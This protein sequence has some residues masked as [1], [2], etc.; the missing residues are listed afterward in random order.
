ME[1]RL[2]EL[3]KE[4]SITQVELSHRLNIGQNTYSQYE[5]GKREIPLE[6]LV[7]LA[8]IYDTSLDYLVGLTDYDLPYP[9]K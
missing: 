6:T 2:K 7:Q 1:L 9:H 4:R 8:Q 3:R 5:T